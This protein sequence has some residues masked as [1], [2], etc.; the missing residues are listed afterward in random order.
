[1]LINNQYIDKK[2]TKKNRKWYESKGYVFSGY[3]ELLMV[4]AQDLSNG[5]HDKVS[6]LCD[7][8]G[9]IKDVV[10]KDYFNYAKNNTKYAC[11]NCR[12]TKTSEKTLPKRQH[13]V[14]QKVIRFCKEKEYTLMTKENEIKDCYTI[15]EYYCKRHGIQQSTFMA[16]SLEHGCKYCAWEDN[17]KKIRN[18]VEDVADMFE[19]L[20]SKLLNK[21]DY[22]CSN[23]KNLRAICPNCGEPF[24]TSLLAF[25]KRNGQVCPDCSKYETRGELRVEKYLK[26]K[27]IDYEFQYRFDDCKYKATLPFDFYLPKNRIAIEYDG[28]FH[29]EPV[30]IGKMTQEQA[31]NNYRNTIIRDNIK[32][33]YCMNNNIN[34]IRIPYWDFDNI[35]EILEERIK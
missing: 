8:C 24:T 10:W 32:T 23:T 26:S 14:Y 18:D 27:N 6:V 25:S 1:M 15:A 5:S 28:I 20:G 22:I 30:K 7:Y 29:F 9:K 13:E 35:E 31:E 11:C 34:L 12:Q 16:L 3:G 17:G 4:K 21:E 19:K 33:D 2:W